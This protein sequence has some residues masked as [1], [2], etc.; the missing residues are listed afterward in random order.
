MERSASVLIVPGA[1]AHAQALQAMLA[2]PEVALPYF[3]S[4]LT[5]GQLDELVAEHWC[6]APKPG[7]M[8]ITACRREDGLVVGAASLLDDALSYFVAPTYWGQGIATQ[9][10]AYLR[11]HPAIAQA[12]RALTARIYRENSASIALVEK[13]GFRF[14]GLAPP[15][16][17]T[18]A[19]RAMLR[20]VL[21]VGA[22]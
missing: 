19:G 5:P 10:I 18:F 1:L 6:G 13:L 21:P 4:M 15:R 22:A 3:G 20:Y 2:M 9:M 14:M 7:R 17:H 12:G 16:N 11:D 8:Q